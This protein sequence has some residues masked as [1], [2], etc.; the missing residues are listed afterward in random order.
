[1]CV[2]LW[3]DVGV[4]ERVGRL[5]ETAGS[6]LTTVVHALAAVASATGTVVSLVARARKS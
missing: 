2:V 1:M 3:M 6:R 5:T 4:M